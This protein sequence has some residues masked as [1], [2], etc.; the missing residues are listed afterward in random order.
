MNARTRMDRAGFTLIEVL[1]S[2]VILSFLLIVGISM[3]R[4]ALASADQSV[5]IDSSATKLDAAL[6]RMRAQ[7]VATS[8][9]TL[10]G[11]PTGGTAPENMVDGVVYTNIQFRRVTGISMG[12][13][14]FF[15]P[16]TAPAMRFY[17]GTYNSSPALLFD[18]GAGSTV[19][20]PDGAT[21]TFTKTG[22]QVVVALSCPATKT[23]AAAALATA[24]RLLVP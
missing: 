3:S 16:L 10:Q 1:I 4:T 2:A 18:S 20:V 6:D 21:A 8:R 5:A 24:F 7:F 11:I 19:L 12:A 17:I 14:L 23:H 13:P 9:G 22:D 15:P